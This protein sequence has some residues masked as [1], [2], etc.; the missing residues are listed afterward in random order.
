MNESKDVSSP[1][2]DRD[3]AGR[4]LADA[5][6]R[7]TPQ[8]I[9]RDPE[10]AAEIIDR[11]PLEDRA[12]LVARFSGK[13]RLDLI[14]A[15]RESEALTRALPAPEFW[16]TVKQVGEEDS[17]QLL[18]MASP[19]Q[20][21]H[22][23]DLECWHKDNLD[24]LG[25]A[26]WIMIMNQAGP[27]VVMKWFG[28]ADEEF[29]I[30]ALSRFF[31]VYRTDPDNEGAEPWRDFD[32]IWTLDNVYYLH[33]TDPKLA[34]TIERMMETVRANE[35]QKYYGLL[36]VVDALASPETE[37]RALRL[38]SARLEDFG[39]VDWDESLGIYAPLSDR[40][41]GELLD[42]APRAG[43]RSMSLERAVAP[44]YPLTLKEAPGLLGRALALVEDRVALE[45]FRLGMATLINRILIADSMDLARLESVE[46]ALDKAHSFVEM[47]LG[48]FSG[49]DLE[50]AGRVLGEINPLL[51]FRAGFTEVIGLARRAHGLK[52]EGWPAKV[53]FGL[54]LMGDDGEVIEGLVKHRPRFYGGLDREGA[55]VFREFASKADVDRARLA[56]SRAQALG[57]LF[58]DALGVSDDEIKLLKRAH[59]GDRLTWEEVLLTAAGQAFCGNGFRFAP[60]AISDAASA[61]GSML[62]GNKPR[63]LMPDVEDELL[64]RTVGELSR[65]ASSDES[66]LELAGQ[67]IK[68]A[69]ARLEDE[70]KDL[71]FA[72]LD[73]RYFTMMVIAPAP[74]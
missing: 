59:L 53:P 63:R 54:E 56:L 65:L 13:D 44:D 60:L 16:I 72:D 12:R 34:P 32:N 29:L 17:L 55:P 39:F 48:R 73:P 70:V 35:E 26:F 68:H 19:D 38:R 45:D 51:I 52:R 36:D 18:S 1:G 7:L 71:D 67:F 6:G 42:A 4:A 41:L 3:D 43:Q 28:R 14:L 2:L 8:L 30:S 49:G 31:R 10:L 15:S 57:E 11:L 25:F 24:A 27:E 33:F 58:L 62:T 9:R 74:E 5:L 37:A 69:L 64:R 21:Q 61:L 66:K 20:V 40:E 47:G 22:I 50:K 23:L 46:S